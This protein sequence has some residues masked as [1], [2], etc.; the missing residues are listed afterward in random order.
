MVPIPSNGSQGRGFGTAIAAILWENDDPKR[1]RLYHGPED[2]KHK[3]LVEAERQL[4]EYF[5]GKRDAFSLPLDFSGTPFQKKVWAALC[6]IPFG[7]TRSYAQIAKEIGHAKA[8]RA[9]G[10]A[11]GKNPISIIAPPATASSARTAC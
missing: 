7:E 4:L 9:V 8:M 6:R 2:K 3:V 11:N 5:A 1:V 10:S